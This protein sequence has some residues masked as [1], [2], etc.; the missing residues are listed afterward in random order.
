M[1]QSSKENT[2]YHGIP[3]TANYSQLSAAGDPYISEEKTLKTLPDKQENILL[4]RT[5][6]CT[7]CSTGFSNLPL[8]ALLN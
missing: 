8:T 1:P 4:C 2:K 7:Q 3:Q 6:V 5:F